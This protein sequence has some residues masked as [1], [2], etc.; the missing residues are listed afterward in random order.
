M[1]FKYYTLYLIL[2]SQ[3]T[4]A[5]VSPVPYVTGSGIEVTPF[6]AVSLQHNDNVTFENDS[7]NKISSMLLELEPSIM[8]KAEHGKTTHS[9]IYTLSSGSY[10]DSSEDNYLDHR[11]DI[12]SI[13]NIN[14]RNR[15]DLGYELNLSHEA[16]GSGISEGISSTTEGF[17]E[18]IEFVT[19][20]VN[21]T[22]IY[23]ADGAKGRLEGSVGYFDKSYK[24]FRN[25]TQFNDYY[26]NLYD[27]VFYYQVTTATDLLFNV[28]KEDRR[29]DKN[30]PGQTTADSDVMYYYIGAEWD[31]TG[32]TTGTI[33]LGMQDKNF[34]SAS[35]EDFDGTSW[36]IG[37]TWSPKSYSTFSLNTSQS[38]ED[39][40]QAGDYIEETI[41]SIDWQHYWRDNFSTRVAFANADEDYTGV[42]RKDD[43]D[44]YG[45]SAS[46]D[47]RRWISLTA[48]W[49]Y[50]DKT[51]SQTNIGYDQQI[52]Y[53]TAI[54]TL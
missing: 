5:A 54:F 22:Y 17:D 3:A 49:D 47:I 7:R 30:T 1:S 9:A 36:D 13:W 38:A 23:G 29:Y 45:I 10:F 43:T 24:N 41:Y 25:T 32:K 28:R 21:A 37:I 39:P 51:S 6:I 18:P 44:Y 40:D 2:M 31:I 26:E 46:Y 48:G 11:F 50:K 4:M 12:A 15:L 16:R 35:R 14:I 53:L 42:S 34:K 52:W 27:A 8:A 33:K 19:N 20:D